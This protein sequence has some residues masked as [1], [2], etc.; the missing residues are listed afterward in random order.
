MIHYGNLFYLGIWVLQK[1][2]NQEIKHEQA[3]RKGP[4]V[5]VLIPSQSSHV[6]TSCFCEP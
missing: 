5:P 4:H 2:Q 1:S 3:I 6:N